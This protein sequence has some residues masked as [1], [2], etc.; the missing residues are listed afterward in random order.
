MSGQKDNV[1][2]LSTPTARQAR[3]VGQAVLRVWCIATLVMGMAWLSGCAGSQTQPDEDLTQLNNPEEDPEGP[4]DT[5]DEGPGGGDVDRAVPDRPKKTPKRTVSSSTR[6][7]LESAIEEMASGDYDDAQDE[8]EDLK[9]DPEAGPLANYNLGVLADRQGRGQEAKGYFEEALRRDPDL[10]PA[11]VS[12]VRLYLRDGDTT[13][14]M[15]TADR[16]TQARP[17]NQDLMEAKLLVLLHSGRFEEVV[18]NAKKVLRA[19]ET[20]TRAMLAMAGAYA[21]LGK[22]ELS[23]D[24]L[25]QILKGGAEPY[26]LAEVHYRLG[27]VYMAQDRDGAAIGAFRSAVD[28]RPDFAEA[29]NNLGVLYHK[30]RDY[31]NAIVHFREAIGIYPQFKEAYLNLG[32]AHKGQKSWQEAEK[33]FLKATQLASDFAP[34]YFNLGVLYL[35]ATFDGRDRKEQ[36]QLAIDNFNRYKSEMKSS[37]ARDDPADAYIEEAKKKIELERKREEMERQMLKEAEENPDEGFEDGE[38]GGEEGFEDGGDD[39]FE[40]DK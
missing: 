19:D 17:D 12:L 10:A 20:N 24:I 22:H 31:E 23:E 28:K 9:D 25:K 7:A 40:E 38:E 14:A 1:A 6:R 39:G 36:F 30:A 21:Q 34:A 35:D 2:H 18:S 11:L 8:F 32:N 16:Y 13:G 26:V 4:G 15:R 27:F 3:P 33:A 37:L 5:V 29:R